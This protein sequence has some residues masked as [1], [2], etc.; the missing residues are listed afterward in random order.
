[1][2]VLDAFVHDPLVEW[3]D[4]KRRM[5]KIL[6]LQPACPFL[7]TCL[8]FFQDREPSKRSSSHTPK[9]KTDL[10]VL[11]KQALNP[12]E[13]KLKGIYSTNGKERIE[14]EVSTSNLVQ[15]LIQEATDLSNLVR[16]WSSD[17]LALSINISNRRECT[18]GGLR[19][20]EPLFFHTSYHIVNYDIHT[21]AVFMPSLFF[22]V[23]LCHLPL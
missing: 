21:Y 15:M 17:S 3:E 16:F 7:S 13:K 22:L 18:L 4:E 8:S 6:E 23:S 19:G 14:R 2:S 20:T 5:V 1:M 12:V 9:V 10:R 11:A